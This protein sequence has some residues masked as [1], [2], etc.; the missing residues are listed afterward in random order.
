MLFICTD[1]LVVK[2]GVIAKTLIF[3]N[4][5]HQLLTSFYHLHFNLTWILKR[6]CYWLD[7]CICLNVTDGLE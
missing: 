4:D 6:V 3:L 7:V 2:F 5:I 1:G